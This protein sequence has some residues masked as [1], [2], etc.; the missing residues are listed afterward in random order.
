MDIKGRINQQSIEQMDKLSQIQS[1]NYK[2]IE[3]NWKA[4]GIVII[5]GCAIAVTILFR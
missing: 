5:I 1:G 4:I 3:L 2:H